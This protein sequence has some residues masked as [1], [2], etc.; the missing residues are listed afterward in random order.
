[1]KKLAIGCV[2]LL[3][4]GIGGIAAIPFV[5]SR[6]S[7]TVSS[8]A[9]GLVAELSSLPELEQA[10]ERQGP[11]TPPRPASPPANRSNSWWRSS[12]RSG[13]AWAHGRRI[14][15]AVISGW[16]RGVTTT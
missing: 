13:I 12:K 4:L 6:I 2:V 3:V 14:W 15:R 5:L 7:R 10:V 1:M 9:E 11:Y 16:S 8:A